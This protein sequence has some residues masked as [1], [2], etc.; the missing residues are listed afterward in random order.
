MIPRATPIGLLEVGLHPCCASFVANSHAGSRLWIQRSPPKPPKQLKRK[1]Q[2]AKKPQKRETKAPSTPAKRAPTEVASRS[3]KQPEP[4]SVIASPSGRRS[5]A[6]KEQAN[7]K[8]DAQARALAE[9]NRQA[10]QT[11]APMKETRSTRAAAS[12][13]QPAR[14]PR[15]SLGTR[16]SA[17]L[18]GTATS[19]EEEDWQ[20]IPK[21]W[22]EGKD[23]PK[24][25][26][27]TGLES[28]DESDL[29]ELSDDSAEEQAPSPHDEEQQDEEEAEEEE[30][31]AKA[32]EE[33]S[34]PTDFVE[35]ET[36]RLAD[37]SHFT[38]D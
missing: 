18:R 27:T 5:R 21:D 38:F 28:D 12:R 9:L 34:Q 35:W 20:P 31:P 22:L 17:R 8:L 16:T 2:P 3:K 11:T 4:T 23:S 7:L 32:E 15:A 33:P 37:F 36:V 29:T 6:A 30:D 10:K 25:K 26:P 1:R 14:A 24:K 13:V 19:E